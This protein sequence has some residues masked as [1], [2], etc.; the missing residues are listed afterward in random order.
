M[1]LG[2]YYIHI[3]KPTFIIDIVNIVTTEKE[4]RPS[5]EESVQDVADSRPL[6]SHHQTD[7]N[8]EPTRVEGPLLRSP[9]ASSSENR[10]P[11]PS[12]RTSGDP[13]VTP[14]FQPYSRKVNRSASLTTSDQPPSHT[15]DSRPADPMDLRKATIIKVT[16]Q[17]TAISSVPVILP[18]KAA[19]IK[20]TE[21]KES[22]SPGILCR[23]SIKLD[24]KENRTWKHPER[25][26]FVKLVT[27]SPVQNG[28][29]ALAENS[30]HELKRPAVRKWSLGLPRKSFPETLRKDHQ[31]ECATRWRSTPCLTLIQTPDPHQSP[32]EVLALNTAAIITNIKLLRQLSKKKPSERG[33]APSPQENVGIITPQIINFEHY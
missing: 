20:V 11:D 4:E 24:G 5:G 19:I 12:R 28:E 25:S 21:H 14:P 22:Y 32:E 2:W 27:T 7:S 17:R 6:V 10:V 9:P 23:N 15:A 3:S 18:R 31:V 29:S 26:T 13:P 30:G 8:R 33:F 16:E 1:S